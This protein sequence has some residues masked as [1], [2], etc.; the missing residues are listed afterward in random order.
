MKKSR[1]G[2]VSF[3]Y[4]TKILP[5]TDKTD[6]STPGPVYN[7][8][9]KLS[10]GRNPYQERSPNKSTFGEDYEKW[11]RVQYHGQESHYLGREGK[12]PGAYE[13]RYDTM[14]LSTRSG[15]KIYSLPRVPPNKENDSIFI[16]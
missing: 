2:Q 7:A 10:I 8:H 16:E 5:K 3:G 14:T 12:G 1:Y 4:G 15:P 9:E 13:H 6:E 11:E